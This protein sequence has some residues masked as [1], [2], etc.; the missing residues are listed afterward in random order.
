MKI[1]LTNDDG[2]ES[3]GLEALRH[4]LSGEHDVVVVAP[5]SERSGMSHSMT[6]RHPVLLRKAGHARYSCSGSPADCVIMTR[7][8]AVE[9]EP[10]MVVSGINDSPNLGTDI[11]YSGTCAAARQA[12]F[13]GIPSIAVS[14]AS[15][16]DRFESAVAFVSRR[17]TALLGLHRAGTFLNINVPV[18]ADPDL[19]PVWAK[20]SRRIYGDCLT[21]FDAP[22]GYSYCFL[23]GGKA[24]AV[25]SL[26]DDYSITLSGRVAISS[27]EVEPVAVFGSGERDPSPGDDAP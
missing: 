13:Y 14:M 1:L 22:D 21:R 4:S 19:P 7:L 17:I 20:P 5:D 10:D 18:D 25:P 15:S 6:L 3:P 23:T 8:G 27:I 24:G 16:T 11:V 2:I 26:A 9:F 12:A